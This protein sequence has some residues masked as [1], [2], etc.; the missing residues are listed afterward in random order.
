V[1]PTDRIPGFAICAR[2]A[3]RRQLGACNCCGLLV[4]G[5]CRGRGEC[6]VCHSERRQAARRAERRA[7]LR[8]AARR[9]AVVGLVAASGA[10]G[11]G[12]AFLPETTL[13]GA[14]LTRGVP[15]ERSV[16]AEVGT[17]H[18]PMSLSPGWSEPLIFR[19]FTGGN[20]VTCCVIVSN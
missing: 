16:V 6:A 7:R 3:A 20:G 1:H 15:A 17:S 14:S 8:E 12:A 5:D 4:C 9:V 11:L 13:C 10:T 2:C 19:C 18:S